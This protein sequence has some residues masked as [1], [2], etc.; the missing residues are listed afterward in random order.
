MTGFV[1]YVFVVVGMV[2]ILVLW[3][4]IRQGV[5]LIR[6][7]NAIGN[8]SVAVVFAAVESDPPVFPG[9]WEVSDRANGLVDALRKADENNRL[10]QFDVERQITP[11]ALRLRSL[12]GSARGAAGLLILVALVSTLLN[13]Q[14]AVSDLGQTFRELAIHAKADN[15]QPDRPDVVD[16]VQRAMGKVADTAGTAFLLSGVSVACAVIVMLAALGVQREAQLVL[17]SF[18]AWAQNG[19][20][21]RV[22]EKAKADEGG[23]LV[24]FSGVVIEFQFLIKSFGNLST[25]LSNLGE[26]RT[27]L[28]NAVSAISSAVEK[29][30]AAIQANMTTLSSKVTS[31]IAADLNRQYTILDRLLAAYGDLGLKIKHLQDFTDKVTQQHGEASAALVKLGTLPAD[32]RK[33]STTVSELTRKTDALASM[34]FK[35]TQEVLDSIRSDL[36]AMNGSLQEFRERTKTKEDAVDAKLRDLLKR[37]DDVNTR[38]TT[39]GKEFVGTLRSEIGVISEQLKDLQGRRFFDLFRG[40]SRGSS[41]S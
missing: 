10:E 4:L 38:M 22:A 9:R 23:K 29:L 19:L 35:S 20:Y 6:V 34:D 8:A 1:G 39:T 32:T 17:R 11:L 21:E 28:N 13:L 2:T 40:G 33:L 15:A 3:T 12:G 14:V 7:R 30:P 16:T 36:A 26:F 27:E 41:S 31:E 5:G 37:A 24:D 18:I 25:E